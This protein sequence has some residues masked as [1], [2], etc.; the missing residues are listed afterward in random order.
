MCSLLS[1]TLPA[2]STGVASGMT[3]FPGGA[4]SALEQAV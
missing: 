2:D 1:V 4:G 3:I